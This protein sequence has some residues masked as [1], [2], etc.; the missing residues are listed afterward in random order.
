MLSDYASHDSSK[1]LWQLNKWLVQT[2][3]CVGSGVVRTMTDGY[4]TGKQLTDA[5]GVVY[6]QTVVFLLCNGIVRGFMDGDYMTVHKLYFHSTYIL[7]SAV[8]PEAGVTTL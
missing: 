6:M 3:V 1:L 5:Q 7:T 8:N 2:L 4:G